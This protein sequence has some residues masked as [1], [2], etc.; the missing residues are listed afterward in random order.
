[1]EIAH[2]CNQS[3]FKFNLSIDKLPYEKTGYLITVAL[4]VLLLVQF[5]R[6]FVV[7]NKKKRKNE[8]EKEATVG[9]EV[10]KGPKPFFIKF[11]GSAY[12]FL[13]LNETL[14][15]TLKWHKHYGPCLTACVANHTVLL[16]F[17]A[18]IAQSFLKSGDLGH[19]SKHKMPFYEIM[20]PLL[21]N[22]LLISDGSYWQ[23]QRKVLMGSMHF[24]RLRSYTKLL[25][26]HSK[27]FV[28]SLEKL[29]VD[30][31]VHQI[32]V[33]INSSFVAIIT[34]VLTGIDVGEKDNKELAEYHHH[35]Q[36]WKD[37][38][39]SRIEKPWCLLDF[40]WRWHPKYEAH[41]DA[42][43]QM[44][45]Y[46]I[47]RLEDYKLKKENPPELNSSGDF[48]DDGK[49]RSTLD[50]LVDAGV[51]DAEI[52]HEIN[53]LIFGG[54]ETTATTIHL[55]F[56]MMALHP[57]FQVVKTLMICLEIQFHMNFNPICE[58]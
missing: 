24:Q 28:T 3:S 48:E 7:W 22:G 56:F 13:P 53:T 47:R 12:D 35:F 43:T 27:R 32:N 37:C 38:M 9:L 39:V 21:G 50:D 8:N 4:F 2:S 11:I 19:V 26:K 6:K 51:S 17:S 46:A 30:N 49:F 58:I 57:E 15:K 5:L 23:S 31:K 54:H 14:N 42:V 44:N 36:T 55:F 45:L 41:N 52:V 18:E 33:Q 29:F 10:I 16:V 40:F 34:E 1:M 20:R 25:N